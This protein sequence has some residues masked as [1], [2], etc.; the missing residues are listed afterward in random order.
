MWGVAGYGAGTLTLT[1]KEQAP[2]ETDLD[3][4]MGAVGARGVLV[5]A[6]AEGGLELAAKSDALLVR[7]SSERLGDGMSLAASQADVSRL[8]LGLEG[9]FRGIATQGGGRF[10]PGFALGVRHDGGDAERGFG[11]DIGAGLAWTDPS[12]GV[13]AE[14]RARGLLTHEAGGFRE[15][16][17]TGAFAWDPAPSTERGPS[18]TLRQTVGAPASGGMDAL[19]GPESARVL[20]AED[21]DELERRT[22]EAKLGYG[23]A[24]F[25]ER[26]TSTPSLGLSLTDTHR[27]TVLGLR[28]GE[29]RTAGL[30]FGLD[31]EGARRESAAGDDGPEHR[32]GLGFGW[33]LEGAGAER[34]TIRF[35]GVRVDAANDGGPEHRLGVNLTA[36]W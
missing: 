15:R 28:L 31:V 11:A 34:F 12:R 33:R 22:L 10:E 23:F 7:T 36:R 14:L 4:A 29:A 27:E 35:E 1:P 5:Q 21:G 18:L 17:F 26:F 30:V 2:M 3:L 13:K 19:L 20:G 9:T 8:R 25:G 16:G 6:P 24:A 32:L